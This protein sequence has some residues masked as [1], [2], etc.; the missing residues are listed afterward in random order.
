MDKNSDQN[1]AVINK[2]LKA[3]SVLIGKWKTEGKHRLLPGKILLGTTS[4][5]WINEGAFIEVSSEFIDDEIPNS[6]SIIGS[7]EHQ[8]ECFMLY[9]DSRGV[10]RKY[11]TSVK[12]ILWHCRREVPN[13]SQRFVGTIVDKGNTIIGVWE[14]SEDG[15]T[16]NKDLEL[17]YTK[18]G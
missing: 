14:L 1:P 13:F 7:D 17:T 11:D 12:D 4:I 3:F 16:W 2:A 8:K 6:I 10:S 18:L 5:K 9:F 15:S